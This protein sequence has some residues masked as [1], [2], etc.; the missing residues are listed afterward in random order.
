MGYH[1][2]RVDSA[3]EPW[4]F[5]LIVSGPYTVTMPDGRNVRKVI[6][7]VICDVQKFIQTHDEGDTISITCIIQV[8]ILR[9]F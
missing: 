9:L 6:A 1:S 7:D 4:A 5:E 3:I 2:H 8:S